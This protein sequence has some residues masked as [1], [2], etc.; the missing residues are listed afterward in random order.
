MEVFAS[1]VDDGRRRGHLRTG[2]AG[3]AGPPSDGLEAGTET[4]IDEV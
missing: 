1:R 3:A 4:L 2:A